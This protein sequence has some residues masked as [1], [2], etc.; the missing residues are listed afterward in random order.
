MS[1]P[2]GGTFRNSVLGLALSMLATDCAVA[3][4][5]VESHETSYTT[6]NFATITAAL[7]VAYDA[8]N[9]AATANGHTNP[10]PE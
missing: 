2:T 5:A 9:A 4:A 10:D 6:E 8:I 3:L 1:S 7:G